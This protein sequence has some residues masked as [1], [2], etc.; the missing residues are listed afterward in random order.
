ME[1]INQKKRP[2]SLVVV[3]V[4]ILL[5]LLFLSAKNR[6]LNL[7]FDNLLKGTSPEDF[8]PKGLD[9]L[10]QI[11][12]SDDIQRELDEIEAEIDSLDPSAFS[13]DF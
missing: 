10:S 5:A 11:E 9:D 7:N 1:Q 6:G 2:F 12:D 8:D 4:A 3:L 13:P